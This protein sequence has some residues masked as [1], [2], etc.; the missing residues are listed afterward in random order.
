SDLLVGGHAG[1]FQRT[2]DGRGPEHGRG[3][4]GELAE[5]GT[6]GGAL[7]TD[8]DDV[9]HGVSGKGA[10]AGADYRPPCCAAANA[11][12]RA[13]HER[14]GHGSQYGGPPI[15]WGGR[16]RQSRAI[17]SCRLRGME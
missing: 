1:L 7:G 15:A 5:E 11:I 17:R 10:W 2:L 3:D 8:D 4:A 13:M 9:A 12:C 6:D 16:A 14:V